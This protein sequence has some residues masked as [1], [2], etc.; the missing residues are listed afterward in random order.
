MSEIN[1]P[2]SVETERELVGCV[3]LDPKAFA[4]LPVSSE[5]F[6]NGFYRRIWETI[7]LITAEGELSLIHI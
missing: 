5:D 4:G 7:E 2:Q 3:L 6:Y 1:L